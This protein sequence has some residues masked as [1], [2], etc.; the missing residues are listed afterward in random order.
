M[1]QVSTFLG[2]LGLVHLSAHAG[3][4]AALKGVHGVKGLPF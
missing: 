1:V 2:G 3:E 4:I